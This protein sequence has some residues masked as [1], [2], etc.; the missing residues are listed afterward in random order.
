MPS[1]YR[2]FGL[3]REHLPEPASFY[4]SERIKLLGKGR[5]RGALCPFH[6]DTN[7]SLRV[8][9]ATGAFCCMACGAKGRDVL[10]FY[11][12][13]HGLRFVDAAKALG[14]WRELP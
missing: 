8:L 10:A 4:S 6:N 3:I 5:W 2:R 14:A 7:P 1:T 9:C 11:M 13:R 12:L